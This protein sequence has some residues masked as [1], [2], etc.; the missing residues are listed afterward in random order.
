[1]SKAQKHHYIPKFYTKRWAGPDG[2]LIEYRLGFQDRISYR[3]TYPKGT[4]YIRGLNTVDGLPHNIANAIED[5]FLQRADD[6]A[7]QA[8]DQFLIGNININIDLRSGWTRFIISLLH[9][10]PER[11]K[12]L[13]ESISKQY[14]LIRH[15]LRSRYSSERGLRDLPTFEEYEQTTNPSGRAYAALFQDIV[16]SKKIGDRLNGMTWSLITLHKSRFALLTSD[17]PIV[18]TN[19]IG[20]PDAHIVMPI[21]P[22]NV[23]IAARQRAT[24][25][26]IHAM[27]ETGEM[28]NILNDRVIRHARKYV[29]ASK[30][31]ELRYLEKRLGERAIWSPLTEADDL[32]G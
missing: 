9:R 14:S 30:S 31:I 5:Q 23:F 13:R 22:R 27:A 11:V 28:Q 8:L 25:D 19:G 18:M 2:R 26:Q 4:G 3:W 10:N 1:M 20:K 16:D 12:Y 6:L 32:A 29:Y 7:C 21:S 24:I 17:R 15:E